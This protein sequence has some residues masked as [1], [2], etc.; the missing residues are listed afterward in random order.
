MEMAEAVT[1]NHVPHRMKN[2][3]KTEFTHVS[4]WGGVRERERELTLK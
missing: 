3:S 4:K 1:T 2:A